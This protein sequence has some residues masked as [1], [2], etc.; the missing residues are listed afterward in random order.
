MIK[1]VVFDMDDTLYP[2][3]E[4]VK[5]G[6]KA[7]DVFLCNKGIEGFYKKAIELF[8]KD[9]KGKIFDEVLDALNVSY[10]NTYIEKLIEVYRN[11]EPKIQLSPDTKQVLK[12]LGEK[13]SL[14]LITD[15]Y[16]Q[17]QR[18]KVK[19]LG[20]ESYFDKIV[21]TDEYG[22]ENWKPSK[23]PYEIV[24]KHFDINHNDLVYIGDNVKKDFISAKK[25]GWTTIQVERED[26]VYSNIEV[27]SEY[28][29]HYQVTSLLEVIEIINK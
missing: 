17:T 28:K 8:E 20:I 22:R 29:A 21:F 1:A 13:Y 5:S 7:I 12:V 27:D 4:F 25:L 3:K 6:F 19:S 15:G 18:N 11:H 10:D 2:E 9:F 16:L 14:A 24:K 26:G 23:L